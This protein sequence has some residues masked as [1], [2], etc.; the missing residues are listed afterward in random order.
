MVES[1]FYSKSPIVVFFLALKKNFIV[2]FII[3]LNFEVLFYLHTKAYEKLYP[4]S[5]SKSV[6]E[7]FV[8]NTF[9]N[10]LPSQDNKANED[11]KEKKKTRIISAIT[12]NAALLFFAE[13]FLYFFLYPLVTVICVAFVLE[14][15]ALQSILKH[16]FLGVFKKYALRIFWINFKVSMGGLFWA[17]FFIIPGIVY[18]IN[19]FVWPILFAMGQTDPQ[20][21]LIKS[22]EICADKFWHIAIFTLVVQLIFS[23]LYIGFGFYQTELDSNSRLLVDFL[24]SCLGNM[25]TPCFLFALLHLLGGFSTQLKMGDDTF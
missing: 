24:I 9:I 1:Q 22:R 21:V 12:M 10:L 7:N 11:G 23:P 3:S 20:G 15:F 17:L 8:T 6:I 18:W 19:R 13:I 14:S 2:L 4:S 16:G 5:E 25:T